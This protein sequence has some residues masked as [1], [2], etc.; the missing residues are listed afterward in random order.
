MKTTPIRHIG[1]IAN[2]R[3]DASIACKPLIQ[4]EATLPGGGESAFRS[5]NLGGQ[6]WI[7]ADNC[8]SMKA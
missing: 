7:G 5:S 3:N 8:A 4:K 6:Y 2:P 1:T